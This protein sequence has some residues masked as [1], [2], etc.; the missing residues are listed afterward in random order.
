MN[1]SKIQHYVKRLAQLGVRRSAA[2]FVKR[3]Q[4]TAYDQW[5][6]YCALKGTL[7]HNWIDIQRA[8]GYT[9]TFSLFFAQVKK[10]Q[11]H[12]FAQY[13]AHF[14]NDSQIIG[15]ANDLLNNC[16][17]IL[18]S[19]KHCFPK[20]P[21]H[22]DFKIAG[23]DGDFPK[24]YYKDIRIS[25]GQTDQ[26]IKDIKVP[27]ELS[28]FQHLFTLGIAYQKTGD[29]NYAN[30]FGAQ[31]S[32]WLD[33][34]SLL[35]GVNWV[36]P[37]DVAIRV[38][39]WIWGFYFFKDV[40]TISDT[41]WQRF[42]CALYDHMWYLERNWELYEGP[43]SNHYLSDLIGYFYLCLIFD[44]I[45][46]QKKTDWCFA[47]L[48]Q[49]CD[50]QVFDEGTDYEG[51]TGY[52]TLV[53]EIFYHAELISQEL[54][55]VLP[56]RYAEKLQRM[57]TFIYWCTFGTNQLQIGD[58]DSG[59]IVAGLS[60]SLISQLADK[61][62]G[63]MH[64]NDFGIS[65]IKT[66][67]W[68]IS[69]RHHAYQPRQ[70]SGHFHYDAASITLAI[71]NIPIIVDPGSYVYTSSKVWRNRFR[72]VN[73]H[74]SF[75]PLTNQSR[76]AGDSERLF[77]LPLS[78]VVDCGQI[79]RCQDM[80]RIST[81]NFLYKN[82]SLIGCRTLELNTIN[83]ELLI[84]DCWQSESN[85]TIDTEWNF[86]LHPDITAVQTDGNFELRSKDDILLA[87]LIPEIKMQVSSG[88]Y[89]PAY[90]ILRQTHH[91]HCQTAVL[92]GHA[93]KFLFRFSVS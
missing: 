51:S 26:P 4:T 45:L 43:T 52:H 76:F 7:S 28:R 14:T 74:N 6:R 2:V 49:E 58:N 44:S 13:A 53:T 32:D 79:E 21:W 8:T 91:L 11:W 55:Y 5:Y 87:T 78:E 38:I 37:M 47:A 85:G 83:N 68:H 54:G 90:G 34:N 18:G 30:A 36:C 57:F 60:S 1:Q 39:N 27:W 31:V 29:N 3:M 65:I 77:E 89:S 93:T 22:R 42:V 59:K 23:P 82:Q 86:T 19:G 46:D 10:N 80:I 48:M 17:D 73:P 72:S 50:T 56:D 40:T 70:P 92:A 9:Q 84:I 63:F 75:Y 88:Y 24:I 81:H 67:Q 66:A 61:H 69:V 20:M 25:A 35:I 62:E 12:S 15:H 16:F 41:F 64:Y 33:N 71:N